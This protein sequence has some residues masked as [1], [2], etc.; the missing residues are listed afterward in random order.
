MD[1]VVIDSIVIGVELLSK[2]IHD[3]IIY[4]S[5]PVNIV[6]ARLAALT[7]IHLIMKNYMN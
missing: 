5:F 2:V 6:I 3:I 7:V 4:V 1:K